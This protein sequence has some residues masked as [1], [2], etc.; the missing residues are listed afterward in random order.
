MNN[1][2]EF[3]NKIK[4]AQMSEKELSKEIIN[5]L[6]MVTHQLATLSDGLGTYLQMVE[7][8]EIDSQ[9]DLKLQLIYN[10][11]GRFLGDAHGMLNSTQKE[12]KNIDVSSQ[13][14]ME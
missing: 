14:E 6:D 1:R 7:D 10:R 11:L 9:N 4:N 8:G 5:G 12:L 3:L 2:E 13:I